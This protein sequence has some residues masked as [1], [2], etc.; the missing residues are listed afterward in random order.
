MTHRDQVTSTLDTN[1]LAGFD[2]NLDNNHH[3]VEEIAD[4]LNAEIAEDLGIEAEAYLDE[5]GGLHLELYIPPNLQHRFN[6]PSRSSNGVISIMPNGPR[7]R[8]PVP[9]IRPRR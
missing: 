6:Q 1:P 9:I 8:R 4:S 3:N 5:E 7:P 2:N